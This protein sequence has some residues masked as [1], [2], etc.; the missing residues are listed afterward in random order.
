MI[1]KGKDIG[2]RLNAMSPLT[3]NDEGRQ[4][5]LGPASETASPT[6]GLDSSKNGYLHECRVERYDYS[7]TKRFFIYLKYQINAT[8]L[9]R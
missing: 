8:M 3:C 7:E 1:V 2:E 5:S 9:V 6:Q 4:H